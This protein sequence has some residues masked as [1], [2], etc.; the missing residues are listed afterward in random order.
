MTPADHQYFEYLGVSGIFGGIVSYFGA[1]RR[2]RAIKKRMLEGGEA[3][4]E[5]QRTYRAYP[6]LH[7]PKW[8]RR[9]AIGAIIAGLLTLLL[10]RM[11]L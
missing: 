2:A 11:N 4:F 3:Y 8:I 6:R 7:D 10:D 5:E 1:E 9:S